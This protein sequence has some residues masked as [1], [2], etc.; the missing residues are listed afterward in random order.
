MPITRLILSQPL[1]AR[2]NVRPIAGQNLLCFQLFF[3]ERIGRLSGAQMQHQDQAE[4]QDKSSHDITC[5]FCFAVSVLGISII[6]TFC[7]LD[8]NSTLP[9]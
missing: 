5:H 7:T 1:Q 3:I 4:G 6:E 9:E 2:F 8:F